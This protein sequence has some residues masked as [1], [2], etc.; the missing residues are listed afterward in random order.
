MAFAFDDE[1]S[2]MSADVR[3]TTQLSVFVRHQNEG[4]VEAALEESEGK[5]VP[6]GFDAIGVA[7]PLPASGKNSFLLEVEVARIGVDGR[8]KCRGAG[9]VLVDVDRWNC[10]LPGGHD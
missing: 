10:V 9:D 7:C 1:S 8:G 6:G 2:A 3:Q 5:N 4:L